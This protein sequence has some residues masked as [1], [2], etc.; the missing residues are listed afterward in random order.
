VKYGLSLVCLLL[1]YV[2][3]HGRWSGYELPLSTHSSLV[4]CDQLLE[5]SSPVL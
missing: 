4:L 5:L 1:L 3:C 2:R